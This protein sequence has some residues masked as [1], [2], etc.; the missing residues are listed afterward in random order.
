M[1]AWLPTAL[2][3]GQLGLD[4]VASAIEPDALARQGVTLLALSPDG[5]NADAIET[6]EARGLTLLPLD[7][8]LPLDE[9]MDALLDG[10]NIVVHG[11]R[12]PEVAAC[13]LV[14][15]GL[16]VDAALETVQN[17]I[18]LPL[19]SETRAAVLAFAG[20]T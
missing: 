15:A 2:W 4:V 12:A 13:L 10:R 3:P 5:L 8:D 9:L 11:E 17:A 7:D 6:A 14:Q 20:G 1:T 19:P 18:A 16:D